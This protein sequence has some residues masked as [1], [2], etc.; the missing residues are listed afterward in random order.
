MLANAVYAS[1]II[2]VFLMSG[3]LVVRLPLLRST[4]LPGSLVAGVALLALGP[5]IAGAQF[6][7]WQLSPDYYSFWKHLPGQLINVVFGCLFLARPVLPLRKMWQQAGPQIAFGQM[8]AWGQYMW[9]GVLALLVLIPIFKM[10]PMV[11]ALIE[12]SFEG[13]HGTAAGLA[14]VFTKVGFPE[15]QD[16]ALGLATVSLCIA[17]ISGVFL[18][19]WGKKRHHIKIIHKQTARSRSYHRR[20]IYEL[21]KQGIRLREHITVRRTTSHLLL[22]AVSVGIGWLLYQGLI[23]LE[24]TTWAAHNPELQLLRYVPF[25][26]LCMFGGMIAHFIWKK[27]GLTVSRPLVELISSMALSVLIASAIATMSL[28]YINSHMKAFMLLAITGIS[29]IL[30]SFIFL[31]RHMFRKNWFQ[32]G[33]VNTAQSMGMTATG[34]LFLHMV[35][36]DDKTS[37]M[38][39]FGYK[40][41]LFEPFV[42]GGVVTALAMPFI[43]QFGLVLFTILSAGICLFWFAAGYFYFGRK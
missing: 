38:E 10:K 24:S 18:V 25:F 26:P 29:W 35:D 23:V 3:Y 16:M 30:L 4:F 42:G 36:P 37:S 6:P 20:I 13:G 8:L 41:L 33:I 39:S 9:G 34:L 22:V 14:P 11:A 17:L 1:F 5:Q 15:G 2:G 27:F 43:L 40:Q 12:M 32:N 19:H 31:A 28:S 7:D 21:N